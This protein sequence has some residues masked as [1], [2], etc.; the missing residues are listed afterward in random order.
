MLKAVGP[1]FVWLCVGVMFGASVVLVVSAY[2]GAVVFSYWVYSYQTL[3]AAIIAIA[4]AVWTVSETVQTARDQIAS[5]ATDAQNQIQ[6]SVDLYERRQKG[7]LAAARALMPFALSDLARHAVT[8][9]R[10]LYDLLPNDADDFD[11]DAVR[12]TF[13][14]QVLPESAFVRLAN[15]IELAPVT[16]REELTKILKRSQYFDSRL[17]DV[18]QDSST[19]FSDQVT[20]HYVRRRIVD[21]IELN[22]RIN[23]CFPYARFESEEIQTG[24][25]TFDEM[26]TAA[27]MS[28]IFLD[29]EPE[30]L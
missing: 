17:E 16:I 15:V 6:N 14:K 12:G 29:E 27:V 25:A 11:S 21:Y 30:F 13:Q 1:R 19:R 4:T 2:T 8:N 24:S 9:S 7:G 18:D 26:R 22:A 23:R 28:K 3:I 20:P 10:R 5:A